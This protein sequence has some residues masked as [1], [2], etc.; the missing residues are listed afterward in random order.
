MGGMRTPGCRIIRKDVS[1]GNTVHPKQPHQPAG[2]HEF[3]GILKT[4]KEVFLRPIRSS[5][6]H[7]LVDLFNRMSAQSVYLRFLRRLDTLS[8]NMI[9]QF[10]KINYH[11]DFALV[12]VVKED[13]KDT[14]V[15]VGRYGYDPEEDSTDLAVAVRD[16]V[17]GEGLGELMLSKV[18]NDRKRK[19]YCTVHGH[20]GFAEQGHPKTFGKTWL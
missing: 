9:H 2:R 15:A 10:L 4:G 16:D 6:G 13:E 14:I 20:H 5:D 11:S 18:R 1:L 17:Q 12:A 8:E 7:L 19:W 3:R